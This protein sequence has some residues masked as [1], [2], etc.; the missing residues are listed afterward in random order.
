MID[1]EE[2]LKPIRTQID[3]VMAAVACLLFLE[4]LITGLVYENLKFSLLIGV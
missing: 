2:L 3:R 1:H 4:T